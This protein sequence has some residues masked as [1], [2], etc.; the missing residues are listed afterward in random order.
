MK[1]KRDR[2]TRK[3]KAGKRLKTSKMISIGAAFVLEKRNGTRAVED[4]FACDDCRVLI[5][6]DGGLTD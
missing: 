6:I 4:D 2:Q 1:M 3:P 5:E